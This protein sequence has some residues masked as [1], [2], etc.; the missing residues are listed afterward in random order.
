MHDS[1]I[2]DVTPDD[3]SLAAFEAMVAGESSRR[4]GDREASPTDLETYERSY[5]GPEVGAIRRAFNAAMLAHM[6]RG[7]DLLDYGCGGV[8]WKDEYWGNYDSVTAA[9]VDRGAL[10]RIAAAYPD[11][12][13]FHTRNGGIAPKRRFDVILSSSVVGYIL[14]E[15]AEHHIRTCQALLRDGGQLVVT[16]VLAFG[17]SAFLKGNRLVR[18]SDDSFAYHYTRSGLID[19]VARNGFKDIR[20][21]HLGVRFPGLPW[22]FN[23]ALY[24]ACPWLMTRVLPVVLPFLRI[25]HMVVARK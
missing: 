18:I 16:R 12:T 8:W 2:H 14:P 11:V 9:E 24:R 7:G 17:V 23:Q 4:S 22:R 13:L 19:L 21:V 10:Q 20:Y 15:Q 3:R 5:F 25:Q 1:I 6:N